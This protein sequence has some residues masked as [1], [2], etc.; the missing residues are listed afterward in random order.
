MAAVAKCESNRVFLPTSPD[1]RL[2]FKLLEIGKLVAGG[3]TLSVIDL[4]ALSSR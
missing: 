4:C 1:L 3:S 2:R